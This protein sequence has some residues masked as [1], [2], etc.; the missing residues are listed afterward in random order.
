MGASTR[1]SVRVS[2]ESKE[3]TRTALETG[4]AGLDHGRCDT[5]KDDVQSDSENPVAFPGAPTLNDIENS[6]FRFLLACETR[7]RRQ[8]R[9]L[10][11]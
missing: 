3:N 6:W 1:N 2:E 8:A 11:A 10:D 7:T 4:R 9:S 5:R